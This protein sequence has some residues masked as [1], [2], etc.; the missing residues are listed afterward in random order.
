[1]SPNLKKCSPLQVV[2]YIKKTHFVS[3]KQHNR[4]V[5]FKCVINYTFI[6]VSPN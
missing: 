2:K 6:G 3:K 4:N 1:V 5:A